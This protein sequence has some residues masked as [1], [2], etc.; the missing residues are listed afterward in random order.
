MGP[1]LVQSQSQALASKLHFQTFASHVF[2]WV[3]CVFQ[4]CDCTSCA[5]RHAH[6][7]RTTVTCM[8]TFCALYGHFIGSAAP[9][10][11][12]CTLS[13]H[14]LCK[15][16][17]FYSHRHAHMRTLNAR[18]VVGLVARNDEKM[19]KKV[20]RRQGA[21]RLPVT[22]NCSVFDTTASHIANRIC[23]PDIPRMDI[24]ASNINSVYDDVPLDGACFVLLDVPLD[25]PIGVLLGVPLELVS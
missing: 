17:A 4:S 6:M 11:P 8:C 1:N 9:G 19:I 24:S 16:W 3:F 20:V 14:F 15:S 7:V 2:K 18:I 5:S 22:D 21:M 23:M 10:I 12:T 13:A 25:V